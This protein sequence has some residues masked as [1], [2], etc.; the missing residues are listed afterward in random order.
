VRL[1][2]AAPLGL[3]ALTEPFNLYSSEA[4]FFIA[5][6]INVYDFLSC[7]SKWFRIPTE[8]GDFGHGG[9][10]ASFGC[11]LKYQYLAMN[12]QHTSSIKQSRIH[13]WIIPVLMM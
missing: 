9:S 6:R 3:A 13:R 11:F 10:S 8:S 2:T 12:A 7:S 4:K 1:A 5:K